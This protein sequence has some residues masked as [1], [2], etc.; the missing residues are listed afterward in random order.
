MTR[1]QAIALARTAARR[2]LKP[3]TPLTLLFAR[4]ARYGDIDHFPIAESSDGKAT[5]QP[6]LPIWAIR[7]KG[8]FLTP[9]PFTCPPLPSEQFVINAQTG[10][11]VMSEYN[12]SN[13]K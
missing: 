12:V 5:R 10:S 1:T 3:G 13:T 4:Y 7:F 6:D 11:L 8:A 9:C 2:N